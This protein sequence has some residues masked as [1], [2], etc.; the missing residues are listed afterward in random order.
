MPASLALPLVLAAPAMC[1]CGGAAASPFADSLTQILEDRWRSALLRWRDY[2]D[3]VLAM[4][5][6]SL[7]D[8]CTRAARD[9]KSSVDFSAGDQVRYLTGRTSWCGVFYVCDFALAADRVG[10]EVSADAWWYVAKGEDYQ[11]SWTALPR[12]DDV[13]AF[14][15]E[16][17]E[18][19]VDGLGFQSSA[20]ICDYVHVSWRRPTEPPAKRARAL[21]GNVVQECSI[22][23]R[24]LHIAAAVPCGHLACWECL[25]HARSS[26]GTCSFC[27]QPLTEIQ[28]LFRP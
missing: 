16:K 10:S 26:S 19:R 1:S 12:A 21:Q 14:F 17:F 15:M 24:N 13:A 4:L 5:E 27:K 20:R 8:A 28:P 6:K 2:E 18:R 7:K 23:R 3:R 25:S 11:G 9:G 22:C